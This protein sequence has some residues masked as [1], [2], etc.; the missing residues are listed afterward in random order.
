[1]EEKIISCDKIEIE[2]CI[3]NLLSNSVKYTE[4]GGE[5]RVY[6]KEIETAKKMLGK[7]IP[8]EVVA[9][10]TGL[11]MEEVEMLS[12]NDFGKLLTIEAKV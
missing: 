5:I 8:V 7:N 3:I 11:T 2:R 10:C 9:E 1:M 6:I 4:E 12:G